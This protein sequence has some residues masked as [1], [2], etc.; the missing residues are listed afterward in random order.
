M[1]DSIDRLIFA[2]VNH[3]VLNFETFEV[4]LPELLVRQ[5]ILVH[6][7]RERCDSEAALNL[8]K[9]CDV[10]LDIKELKFCFTLEGVQH[11]VVRA[12]QIGAMTLDCEDN[13]RVRI[14]ADLAALVFPDLIAELCEEGFKLFSI[15]VNE[16]SNVL[17][18]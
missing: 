1:Q 18:T 11:D 9:A 10:A 15:D 17:D 3:S 8:R 16:R 7:H 6:A 2:N 5:D 14:E 4:A 13:K 12:V